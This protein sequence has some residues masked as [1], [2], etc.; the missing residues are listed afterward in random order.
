MEFSEEV[1]PQLPPA[2]KTERG[3]EKGIAPEAEPEL[4]AEQPE[5]GGE[6][7]LIRQ[8]GRYPLRRRVVPLDHYA[9]GKPIWRRG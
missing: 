5:P 4:S 1:A 2:A 8:S 6:P 3:V 9:Q 7:Q